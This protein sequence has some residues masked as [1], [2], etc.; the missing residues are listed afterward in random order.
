MP[1]AISRRGCAE[2]PFRRC[3]RTFLCHLCADK[4]LSLSV[5]ASPCQSKSGDANGANGGISKTQMK[6]LKKQQNQQQEVRTAAGG[7]SH[8][9]TRK[10]GDPSCEGHIILRDSYSA[11]I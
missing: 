5:P 3:S 1:V 7:K 2:L 8:M 9:E 6:K 4:L 11:V 10:P